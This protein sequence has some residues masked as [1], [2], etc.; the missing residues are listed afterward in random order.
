MKWFENWMTAPGIPFTGTSS[1]SLL[2]SMLLNA[3]PIV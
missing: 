3:S 2:W 1:S